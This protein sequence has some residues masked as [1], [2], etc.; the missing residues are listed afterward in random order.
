MVA[1]EQLAVVD[2]IHRI[3]MIEEGYRGKEDHD[4]AIVAMLCKWAAQDVLEESEWS[5]GYIG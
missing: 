5:E 3:R 4:R 2:I 1:Q